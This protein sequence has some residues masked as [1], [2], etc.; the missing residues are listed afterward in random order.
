MARADGGWLVGWL[1]GWMSLASR[2]PAFRPPPLP[3]LIP[4]FMIGGHIAPPEAQADSRAGHAGP[5]DLRSQRNIIILAEL[6]L[7]MSPI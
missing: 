7:V 4:P 3:R 5:R 6:I 1:D 2:L